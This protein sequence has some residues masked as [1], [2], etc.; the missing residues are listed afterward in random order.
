[1]LMVYSIDFFVHLLAH[2]FKFEEE[3]Y[4]LGKEIEASNNVSIKYQSSKN[5]EVIGY[6]KKM[7]QIEYKKSRIANVWH[8]KT[9]LCRN[10]HNNTN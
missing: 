3:N 8:I 5:L 1:M 9:S 6:L 7:L 2:F 10:K 4:W